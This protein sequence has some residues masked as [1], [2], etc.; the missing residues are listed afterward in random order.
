MSRNTVVQLVTKGERQLH[1]HAIDMARLLDAVPEGTWPTGLKA[2]MENH[3][4]RLKIENEG[5]AA[6]VAKWEGG[7][8]M[9]SPKAVLTVGNAIRE[10]PPEKR[11]QDVRHAFDIAIATMSFENG[12]VAA[13]RDDIASEMKCHPDKVSAAM[14]VLVQWGVIR[15]EL[16][17]KPG[18]RGQG[19]VTYY[20]NPRVAWRGSLTNRAE[21]MQD[22]PAGPLLQ[23]MEGGKGRGAVAD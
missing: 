9:I 13:T 6:G 7:F 18:T 8:V 23:L 14:G 11:P 5:D 15:R 4:H 22:T 2:M 16:D 3:L 17:R 1:S 12:R 21:A 19:T 20:V 10:L